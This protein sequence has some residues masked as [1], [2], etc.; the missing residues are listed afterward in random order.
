MAVNYCLKAESVNERYADNATGIECENTNTLY[1]SA[2]LHNSLGNICGVFWNQQALFFFAHRPPLMYLCIFSSSLCLPVGMWCDCVIMA[3]SSMFSG[4][5]PVSFLSC[6]C[7]NS[8]SVQ[9]HCPSVVVPQQVRT[10]AASPRLYSRVEEPPPCSRPCILPPPGHNGDRVHCS[11]SR[12][13]QT[14]RSF[15][16][17]V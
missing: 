9:R 14:W 15:C 17:C 2:S 1:S 7:G 13:L 4:P 3:L 8:H 12:P 10:H 6:A 5:A 16:T 11:S